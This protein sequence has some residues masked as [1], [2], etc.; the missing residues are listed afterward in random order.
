LRKAGLPMKDVPARRFVAAPGTQN[1]L[2]VVGQEPGRPRH[3]AAGNRP[4]DER[5]ELRQ[6][7]P[8]FGVRRDVEVSVRGQ[9]RAGLH[10]V[11][12]VDVPAHE[13]GFGRLP[14]SAGAA[15]RRVADAEV[16]AV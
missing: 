6:R 8:V 11:V 5:V 4:G 15:L 12:V 16:V 3:R 13:A 10:P 2:E 9:P 1:V 14:A 7:M